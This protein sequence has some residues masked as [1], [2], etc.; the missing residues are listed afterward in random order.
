[1][2]SGIK[3]RILSEP[4]R[5]ID[6]KYAVIA[7]R[8]QN[9]WIFVRHRERKTWEI[10]GGH[11]EPGETPDDAASRELKEETGAID[12]TILP[13]AAYAVEKDEIKTFGWLYFAE[14]QKLDK[15]PDSE[16]AEIILLD[17]L[18]LNLTYPLIQPIL[19]EVINKS[20]QE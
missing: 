11:I 3:V 4:D 17:Q 15:L 12:F 20:I 9:Q 8:Y 5:N 1:M 10:P 14:I 13:V 2:P 19:F 18:P 16:I 6:F 7:S